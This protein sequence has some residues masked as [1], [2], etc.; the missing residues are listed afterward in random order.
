MRDK[1]GFHKVEKMEGLEII[2]SK[3][4]HIDGK[5]RLIIV[6]QIGLEQCS[7][8]HTCGKQYQSRERECFNNSE[9][10]S[11]HIARNYQYSYQSINN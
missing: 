8:V 10:S 5:K 2:S 11:I 7:T 6:F 3:S 9:L 1:L 4:I